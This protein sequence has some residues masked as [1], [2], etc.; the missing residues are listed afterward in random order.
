MVL[1]VSFL[2][3]EKD[4]SMNIGDILTLIF[5]IGFSVQIVITV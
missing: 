5:A 3:L 2:S 1:G 4:F